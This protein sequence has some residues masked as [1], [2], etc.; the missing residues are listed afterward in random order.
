[1]ASSVF[2][3]KKKGKKFDSNVPRSI[4]R[5]SKDIFLFAANFLL[6]RGENRLPNM[7]LPEFMRPLPSFP[8]DLT[9]GVYD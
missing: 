2:Q 4:E 5:I 9:G 6:K 1:M 8:G 7:E 3:L